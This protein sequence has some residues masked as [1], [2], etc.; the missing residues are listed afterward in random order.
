MSEF[1]YGI[2]PVGQ[3]PVEDSFGTVH[4]QTIFFGDEGKIGHVDAILPGKERAGVDFGRFQQRQNRTYLIEDSFAAFYLDS[5][6]RVVVCEQAYRL[7]MEIERKPFG[8]DTVPFEKE[9]GGSQ[10]EVNGGS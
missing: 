10:R 1:L 7:K 6:G 8:M 5:L 2:E 9:I 4:V 3:R